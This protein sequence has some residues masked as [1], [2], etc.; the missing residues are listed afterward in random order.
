MYFTSLRNNLKHE[1]TCYDLKH[2]MPSNSKDISSASEQQAWGL[3]QAVYAAVR[4]IAGCKWK[5]ALQAGSLIFAQMLWWWCCLCRRILMK[6][7]SHGGW[8]CLSLLSVELLHLE[9]LEKQMNW[10]VHQRPEWP[11]EQPA[12]LLKWMAGK[13]KSGPIPINVKISAC[14]TFILLLKC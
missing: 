10:T 2:N 1:T 9:A 5:T 11:A 14:I 12:D 6:S 8:A 3:E 7:L 4:L 13:Y